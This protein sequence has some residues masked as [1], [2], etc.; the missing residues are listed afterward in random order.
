M[1]QLN[2]KLF[3]FDNSGVHFVKCIKVITKKCYIGSFLIVSV[4]NL[5]SKQKSRIKKGSVLIACLLKKTTF[6]SKFSGLKIRANINGVILLNKQFQPIS[7]RISGVVHR[8]IKI[9][10]LKTMTL[11]G[12]II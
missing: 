12:H 9:S 10:H 4:K 6:F 7:S 11:S 1:V 3:N 2:T 8:E 5:R